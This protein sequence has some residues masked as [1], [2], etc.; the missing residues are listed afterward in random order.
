MKPGVLDSDVSA[1]LYHQ[2][3]VELANRIPEQKTCKQPFISIEKRAKSCGSTLTLQLNIDG[4]KIKDIGYTYETCLLTRAVL[5]VF[6]TAAIGKTRDEVH[7]IYIL[8]KSWLRGGIDK[9]PEEWKELGILAPAKDYQMRHKSM[10]M[11]FTATLE[12]F[13]QRASITE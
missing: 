9:L 8:F 3:L 1:A 2:R 6:C 12:A 7:N 13:D 11:P 4:G 10:M 5:A